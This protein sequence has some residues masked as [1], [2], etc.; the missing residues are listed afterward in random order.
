MYYVNPI[1]PEVLHGKELKS[2]C[3]ENDIRCYPEKGHLLI[4]TPESEWKVCVGIGQALK[5]F[6]KNTVGDRN[7]YH[8][9]ALK[10]NDLMTVIRY[11][12]DHD[13][14]RASNPLPGTDRYKRYHAH[15]HK[16][17]RLTTAYDC[18]DV[19]LCEDEAG[20]REM[21]KCRKKNRMTKKQRREV[22][23]VLALIDAV[24]A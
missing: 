2:F 1:G 6:H 20:F 24:S 23:A 3:T 13:Q 9:Q 18:W 11:I 22:N 15:S 4:F 21:E 17:D 5:L 8:E 12:A 14:Y 7:G 19:Q 10:T 16:R